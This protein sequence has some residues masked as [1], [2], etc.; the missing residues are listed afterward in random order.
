MH[1][2]INFYQTGFR[3][4]QQ[5]F[6]AKSLLISS[7]VIMLGMLV[8][9]GFAQYKLSSATSELQIV[10]NQEKAA[11]ERLQNFGPAITA[12]SGERNF[13]EQL[14]DATHSLR[15]KELVLSLVRGSTLVDARGFY[16]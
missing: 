13:S 12:V 5:L 11:V 14:E 15:E 6:G 9:Y 3:F 4:A 8:T 7:S 16:L 2:Q 10:S 1:Q